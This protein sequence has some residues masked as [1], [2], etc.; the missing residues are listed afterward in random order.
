MKTLNKVTPARNA[1]QPG[2]SS[3]LKIYGAKRLPMVRVRLKK[4]KSKRV[5]I[6][7][8]CDFDAERHLRLG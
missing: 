8:E 4:S 7:N 3:T 5:L 6:V 1:A 2:L